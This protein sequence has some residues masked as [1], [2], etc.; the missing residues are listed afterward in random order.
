LIIKYNAT[1][2]SLGNFMN[3]GITL[4]VDYH[5]LIVQKAKAWKFLLEETLFLRIEQG[6][7]FG[8]GIASILAISA[9]KIKEF[10]ISW[11]N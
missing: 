1:Q 6:L 4:Y 7:C 11:E 10:N 8:I 5:T 2:I 9:G 3:E